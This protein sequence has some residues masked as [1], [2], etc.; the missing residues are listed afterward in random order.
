MHLVVFINTLLKENLMY[1]T[2]SNHLIAIPYFYEKEIE[3]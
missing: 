3:H 2:I 1:D